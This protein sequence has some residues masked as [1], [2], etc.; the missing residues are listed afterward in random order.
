MSSAETAVPIFPL[1]AVQMF[2]GALLPLH[3]F[4]PRYRELVRDALAGTR[5]IALPVLVPGVEPQY[6]ER[7]PVRPVCGL[8]EIVV[9]EPLP[10][11]R[12][13]LLLRGL[14]RVRILDELPPERSY[15][16]VTVAPLADVEPRGFDAASAR[17]ALV[18]LVDRLALGL[19][20]GARVLHELVRQEESPGALADLISAALVSAPDD[21]QEL[22]ETLD[23]AWR[24]ELLS[25]HLGALIAGS[26]NGS[27]P[28]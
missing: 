26:T 4:E 7:P 10:D 16:M 6:L 13:N 9:H 8:G 28:N 3:V 2:P 27:A 18:A 21:R 1:P 20:G 22:L 12:S 5:Q 25:G 17:Q 24:I 23:V 19:E 11:G 14:A 15:R